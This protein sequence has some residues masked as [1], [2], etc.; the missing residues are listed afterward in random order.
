MPTA[1]AGSE[2]A[3]AFERALELD[4]NSFDA[5]LSYARFCVTEDKPERAIELFLRAIEIQPDD[6]QAPMLS[7]VV[8]R[9]LGR[10]R[11]PRDMPGS[12]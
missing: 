2:A 11:K 5:N 4:P 8:F 9:A 12:G 1:I 10:T 3:A 6:S 7:H